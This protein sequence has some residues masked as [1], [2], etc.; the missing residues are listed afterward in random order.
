MTDINRQIVLSK[1]PKGKLA[2]EHFRLVESVRPTPGPDQV[3][4]RARYIAIDAAMRAWMLG[5]TYR[6]ALQGGDVMAGA[7]LAEVVDSRV[8]ES[9][10]G[11]L[12]YTDDAGCQ[13]YAVVAS[14]R[15]A[16]MPRSIT[17]AEISIHR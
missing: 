10:A 4:V 16:S 15:S 9:A 6:A 14:A 8:S 11:D 2:P 12:V 3:L 13:D 7:A 17:R 5:P 1:L